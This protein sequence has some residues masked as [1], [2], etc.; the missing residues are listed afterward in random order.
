MARRGRGYVPGQ[1]T[2]SVNIDT[3]GFEELLA[4]MNEEVEGAVAPAVSAAAEVIVVLAKSNIA[5]LT[6][7]GVGTGNLY[8]AMYKKYVTE[9]SI[10]GQKATYTVTWRTAKNGLP[11]APHGHLLEYGWIQKYARYQDKDTGEWKTNKKVLHKVQQPAKRFMRDAI[12]RGT[13]PALLEMETVL[14]DA[15]I[16]ASL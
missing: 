7:S 13:E 1:N 6:K 12:E 3:S 2:L 4:R 15:M 14:T 8:R 9:E 16:R 5:Q 11:R 10:D